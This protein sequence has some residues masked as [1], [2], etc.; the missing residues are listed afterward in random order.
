MS[1]TIRKTAAGSPLAV[2]FLFSDDCPSHERALQLVRE[3]IAQEGVEARINIHQVETE[4]DA[5]RLAF[6][7]SP[8]IRVAGS[9]IDEIDN[10]SFGLSCRAYRHENGRI[11]PL[12]PRDKIQAAVRRML[13]DDSRLSA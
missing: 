9:D 1:E 11:S 5:E 4:A 13:A 7:G 2:D 3:V 6:P 8:T 12:P 10:A